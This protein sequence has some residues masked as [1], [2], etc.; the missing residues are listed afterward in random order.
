MPSAGWPSRWWGPCAHPTPAPSSEEQG[1]REQGWPAAAGGHSDS[2]ALPHPCVWGPWGMP[3]GAW[4]APV[5]VRQRAWCMLSGSARMFNVRV[6][7]IQ[8]G[9]GE[10][11]PWAQAV[12]GGVVSWWASCSLG[13][14]AFRCLQGAWPG[15]G[16]RQG[17]PGL[18]GPPGGYAVACSLLRPAA[19]PLAPPL[20]LM[21]NPTQSFVSCGVGLPSRAPR[22]LGLGWAQLLAWFFCLRGCCKT[23]RW[24]WGVGGREGGRRAATTEGDAASESLCVL[25]GCSGRERRP[26]LEG[27]LG[28]G[29]CAMMRGLGAD[30]LSREGACSPQEVG[31]SGPL[32]P[33]LS[34]SPVEGA[35]VGTRVACERDGVMALLWETAG[36]W[37]GGWTSQGPE[38]E[39]RWL[40]LE[41]GLC[42]GTA[43]APDVLCPVG[44]QAASLGSSQMPGAPAVVAA[45]TVS[46]HGPVSRVG[47]AVGQ[48]A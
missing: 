2:T 38:Q 31:G 48:L 4:A 35:V 17:S 8:D 28:G 1:L 29:C 34:A 6:L 36:L 9:A 43:K 21:T 10:C 16:P 5:S 24:F 47:A 37:A 18:V 7:T 12:G 45:K 15:K 40:C 25:C 30:S 26:S 3:G 14:A 39:V 11:T 41:L 42:L 46:R 23:R 13:G 19:H 33:W 44:C 20:A 27:L 22:G 32:G